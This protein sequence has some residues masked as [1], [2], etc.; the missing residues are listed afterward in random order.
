MLVMTLCAVDTAASAVSKVKWIVQ[1]RVVAGVVRSSSTLNNVA[2]RPGDPGV[3][4]AFDPHDRLIGVGHAVVGVAIRAHEH[5][6]VAARRPPAP[7]AQRR[8]RRVD[9]H[10]G[11]RRAGQ[12]RIRVVGLGGQRMRPHAAAGGVIPVPPDLFDAGRFDEKRRRQPATMV[13]AC[14][15]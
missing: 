4:E 14:S 6:G 7:P 15:R 10:R 5:L 12:A 2:L 13:A 9:P 1:S 3:G 11:E 8:R